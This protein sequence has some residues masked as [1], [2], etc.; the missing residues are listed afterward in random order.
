MTSYASFLITFIKNNTLC[1]ELFMKHC[2][3][4][5][6]SITYVVY[7]FSPFISSFLKLQYLRYIMIQIYL[8]LGVGDTYPPSGPS[9][10]KFKD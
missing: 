6:I 2:N 9:L 4:R 3:I 1:C 7:G 10:F 5:Y 8:F